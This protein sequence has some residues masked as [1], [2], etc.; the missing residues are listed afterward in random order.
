MDRQGRFFCGSMAYD[1]AKGRGTFYRFD[2]GG[3]ISVILTGVTISNGIAWSADG[4]R[5]FYIDTATQRVD[6]F[7][8]DPAAGLPSGRRPVVHIDPAWAARTDG[9]G[10]RGRD[11]GRP[12]QRP[13]RAPLPG[14]WHPR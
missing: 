12:L 1:E 3:E 7:D 6:V 13:C 4:Q 11:L 9:P 8:Y 2:P 10:R 5:M 14:G